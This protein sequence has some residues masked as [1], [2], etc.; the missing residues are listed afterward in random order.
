MFARSLL[1]AALLSAGIALPAYAQSPQALFDRYDAD[2]DGRVTTAKVQAWRAEFFDRA[3]SDANG[4]VT[5]T[6]IQTMREQAQ[7]RAEEAGRGSNRGRRGPRRQNPIE[8]YDA[9][10]DGQLSRTE[11]VDAPFEA[12]ERFDANGDGALSLDELPRRRR[13]RG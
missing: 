13:P 8:R 6:E 10:Q 7:A 2:G 4:Y 11:Y 12:L 5:E 9:D 3:D 1:A